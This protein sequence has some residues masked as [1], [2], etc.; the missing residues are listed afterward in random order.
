MNRPTDAEG[1]VVWFSRPPGRCLFPPGEARLSGFIQTGG[2]AAHHNPR[3]EG[4]S[5]F[6]PLRT[7]GP[8]GR[9]PSRPSGRVPYDFPQKLFHLF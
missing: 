4:A 9:Q 1:A 3:A 6:R 2:E 8:Q 7:L 5:I